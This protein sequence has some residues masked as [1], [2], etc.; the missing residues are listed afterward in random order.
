MKAKYSFL[1]STIL[2]L[3]LSLFS[4]TKM[5]AQ[6]SSYN[7]DD[8]EQLE[9]WMMILKIDGIELYQPDWTNQLYKEQDCHPIWYNTVTGFIFANEIISILQNAVIENDYHLKKAELLYNDIRSQL[10]PIGFFDYNSL[11]DLDIL[12]TDGALQYAYD[13]QEKIVAKKPEAK[14]LEEETIRLLIIDGLLNALKSESLA[15]YFEELQEGLDDFDISSFEEASQVA[16]SLKVTDDNDSEAFEE[17]TE[18]IGS[19][20]DA[21]VTQTVPAQ[22]AN[23]P[24][25][26][27]VKDSSLYKLVKEISRPASKSVFNQ[28]L[29]HPA[30]IDSFY[31][32]R[33][34]EP[35]WHNGYTLY[36]RGS[37]VIRHIEKAS[38][39]GLASKDYHG[40]VLTK[41]HSDIN[42]VYD[43]KFIPYDNFL[44]KIDVLITDAA[45]HYAYHLHYGK[46]NPSKLDIGW[47]IERDGAFDFAAALQQAIINRNVNQFFEDRKPQHEE[48]GQLKE[49][50]AYYQALQNEKG[51]WM[52]DLKSEKLE[53][54]MKD[55]AV[56][57]LRQR[58]AFEEALPEKLNDHKATTTKVLKSEVNMDTLRGSYAKIEELEN[59][60]ILTKMDSIYNPEVFDITVH[61][62]LVAFQQQHG[63]GDDG[64]IGPNTL[65]VLNTSLEHRIKQINIALEQWRW[66]PNQFSDFFVFVN[67]PAYQLDV[68]KNGKIDQTKK[69]MVGLPNH[70]TA[71]FS[72]NIRYLDL[73]P[74]WTVP[75]SIATNE[76]LPKL[77]QNLSYLNRQNM[78]VFSGG[79]VINPYNVNWS[80]LSSRKF[81]YTIRQEPGTKNAL[82]TVKFMFPNKYNIYLHDTPSKSLFVKAERAYSHGCIRLDNP[83]QF[84]E[85]LLQDDPKWD[86][87]KIQKVL[88][89]EKN[90]RVSLDKKI[91]IYIAYFTAWV[92]A[93]GL[94]H[95]QKDVYGKD[96]VVM[97]AML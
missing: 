34:Y 29:Y 30:W 7:A 18:D 67:I 61:N 51:E 55:K 73:N 17:N 88:D 47:N 13:I 76:I 97:K 56:A 38:Q 96:E 75:F 62:A 65:S 92:D 41:W 59:S 84:A 4:S 57:L 49:A 89:S 70:K 5:S 68:Y 39:E 37:E 78:K 83:V 86:A 58:L 74:Y 54:G 43:V 2:F 14:Q 81:P 50:L 19:P 3:S 91:P 1:I 35:V 87:Q 66:M 53:L 85:Y 94:T 71:I 23:T 79:K 20:E 60:L 52:T 69:V 15:I 11:S 80:S 77:K 27:S 10:L 32:S 25:V 48:Y 45:L 64:V 40:D 22:P 44:P 16:D 93:S 36:G 21:K 9:Q 24:K 72:N 8:C 26:L 12:L 46:L 6:L 42:E 82:G 28:A 31:K 63:I 33:N 95:F 90:T